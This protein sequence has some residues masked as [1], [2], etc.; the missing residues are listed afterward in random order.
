MLQQRRDNHDDIKVETF[1]RNR[2]ASALPLT[3]ILPFAFLSPP[4]SLQ[5]GLVR[6]RSQAAH[7][8]VRELLR[9]STDDVCARGRY[10]AR[11]GLRCRQD[12]EVD[13]MAS[14]K[15][16]ERHRDDAMAGDARHGAAKIFY[17]SIILRTMQLRCLSHRRGTLHTSHTPRKL[18]E[19]S[20]YDARTI[21]FARSNSLPAA[22]LSLRGGGLA[23]SC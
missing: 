19:S 9:H 7:M 12:A 10:D 11:R 20:A 3:A 5:I 6:R 15:G 16:D 21:D 8:C 4:S 13:A 14:V 1:C 2:A 23:S 17:I 18:M 22:A